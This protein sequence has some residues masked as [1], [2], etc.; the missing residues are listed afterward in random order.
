MCAE[1]AVSAQN[2]LRVAKKGAKMGLMNRE[3]EDLFRLFLRGDLDDQTRHQICD[4]LEN[5]PH[6]ELAVMIREHEELARNALNINWEDLAQ[7]L[8][9]E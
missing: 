7:D 8:A 6:G 3:S 9:D 2:T 5:D 4:T 1:R